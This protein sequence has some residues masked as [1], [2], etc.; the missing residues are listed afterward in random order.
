MSDLI[1]ASRAPADSTLADGFTASDLTGDGDQRAIQLSKTARRGGV[2]DPADLPK[3]IWGEV[4]PY[5]AHHYPNYWPEISYY[6]GIWIVSGKVAAILRNHDLGAGLIAPVRRFA[7]DRVTPVPG[8]WFVWNV[9]NLKTA[10][11]GARSQNV[12]PAGSKKWLAMQPKDHELKVSSEAR[13]GPDAWFDPQLQDVLFLS[14]PLGSALIDAD[15]A[16]EKAGF[17]QLI[18]CDVIEA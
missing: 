8:E 3:E 18:K 11:V 12:L 9:G 14:A 15:L 16:T 10:F 5:R 13:S 2:V 7:R 1:W 6:A 4:G 17:G